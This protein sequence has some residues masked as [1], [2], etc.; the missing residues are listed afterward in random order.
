MA[1]TYKPESRRR[2]PA[3]ADL[4][5]ARRGHPGAELVRA[6]LMS[7]TVTLLVDY[8][9]FRNCFRYG[10]PHKRLHAIPR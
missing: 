3:E 8:S 5:P 7:H 4:G 1:K 6:H 10:K 2:G 9:R